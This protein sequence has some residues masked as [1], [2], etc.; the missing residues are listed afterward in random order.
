MDW[1]VVLKVA[2]RWERG[3]LLL[4]EGSVG[5]P[6]VV[7]VRGFDWEARRV[8]WMPGAEGAEWVV[9]VWD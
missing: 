8:S 1:A 5:R 7:E 6:G 2:R 3:W 4:C 9:W